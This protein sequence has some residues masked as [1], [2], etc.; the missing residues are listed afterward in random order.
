MHSKHIRII[1]TKYIYYSRLFTV[2]PTSVPRHTSV[3]SLVV[4]GYT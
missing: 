2:I 1:L 3:S 4:E